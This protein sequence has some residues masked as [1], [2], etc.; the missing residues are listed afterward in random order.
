MPKNMK[1]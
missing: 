1:I